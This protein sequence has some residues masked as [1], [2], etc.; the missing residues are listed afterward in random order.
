MLR[1]KSKICSI[2]LLTT[3]IS[4]CSFDQR[5]GFFNNSKSDINVDFRGDL[6]Y[7]KSGEY[8][9]FFLSKYSNDQDIK[10]STSRCL[11]TFS[12]GPQSLILSTAG[13]FDRYGLTRFQ[14]EDN[15]YVYILERSVERVTDVGVLQ[16]YQPAGF[17]VKPKTMKC[18]S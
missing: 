3:I 6:A 2:V 10:V 18:S 12:S 9:E 8:H 11:I 14:I 16:S 7:I 15:G 1:R 17:P 13:E 4:G 5:Y